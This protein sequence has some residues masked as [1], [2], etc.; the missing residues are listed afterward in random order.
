MGCLINTLQRWWCYSHGLFFLIWVLQVTFVMS[1]SL[2]VSL[3]SFKLG[4]NWNETTGLVR[5]INLFRLYSKYFSFF[6]EKKSVVICPEMGENKAF[7]NG[8]AVCLEKWI[9][10]DDK[11]GL[12]YLLTCLSSG[13]L[14]LFINPFALERLKWETVSKVGLEKADKR[15]KK[16]PLVLGVHAGSASRSPS[17]CE[18]GGQQEL[19]PC[20]T[21]SCLVFYKLCVLEIQ[22]P[23]PNFLTLG[24]DTSFLSMYLFFPQR[25]NWS[26]LNRK[27]L[28]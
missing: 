23:G 17:P 9:Y 16:K 1:H 24:L 12:Y 6:P 18:A 15:R 4:I 26:F 10:W 13:E 2:L 27:N 28:S 11:S 20:V 8:K 25:P 21:G 19:R 7:P 5:L 3:Y 22:A 14:S